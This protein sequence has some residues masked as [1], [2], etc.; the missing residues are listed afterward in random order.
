MELAERVAIVA[1]AAGGLGRIVTRELA[2]AGLRLALVGSHQ[3]RLDA[4]GGGLGT[5]PERWAGISADLRARADAERMVGAVIERFGRVDI[6]VHVVGGWSGDAPVS[7]VADAEVQG[8]LDQHLWTTLNVTRALAPHLVTTGWGRIVA[9]STPVAAEPPPRMA[10]YAVGKAAQEAL[11]ATL[12]REVAGTG[13]TV[14]VLRVR[15]IDADHVRGTAGAPKSAGSWTTPEEIAAAVLFL[16]T[17]AAGAINGARI[18]L[19]GGS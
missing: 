15:K 14:N 19:H 18:P 13:V 11:L 10:P 7:E 6:L 2:A 1:G 5:S 9:V 3:D 17:D 8:M 16:C 4:L 12:A